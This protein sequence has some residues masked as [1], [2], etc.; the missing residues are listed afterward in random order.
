MKEQ[1]LDTQAAVQEHP[2]AQRPIHASYE[3]PNPVPQFRPRPKLRQAP[4]STRRL[5]P[6]Q[7]VA[8]LNTSGTQ[9][10]PE[11]EE[12]PGPSPSEA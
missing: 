2:V 4:V 7:S 9:Q 12:A 5:Y 1:P 10:E 6:T 8:F 3:P 11:P